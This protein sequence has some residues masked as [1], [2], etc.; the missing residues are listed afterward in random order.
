VIAVVDYGA[1]NIAS[2]VKALEAAGG[3]V[4]VVSAPAQAAGAVAL[5]VPGVGHFGA[6]QALHEQWQQPTRRAVD[7][8]LPVLGICLGMQWLF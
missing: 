7:A 4:R 3:V 8:G 6:T 1:G 5:V 2:V